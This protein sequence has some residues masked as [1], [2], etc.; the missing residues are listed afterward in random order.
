MAPLEV[1]YLT[2]RFFASNSVA[3]LNS[4]DELITLSF[5]NPPIVV[6]Q[7]TPRLFGLADELLSV[8]LHLIGVHFSASAHEFDHACRNTAQAPGVPLVAFASA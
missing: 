1:G 6:S 5:D 8:S 4:A 7:L 3:L 2:L